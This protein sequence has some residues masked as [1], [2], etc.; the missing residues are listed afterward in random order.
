MT[1][2]VRPGS[3]VYHTTTK[4]LV[5]RDRDDVIVTTLNRAMRAHQKMSKCRGVE[6]KLAHEYDYRESE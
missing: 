1:V 5:V 4:C 6:C 2:L 3:P